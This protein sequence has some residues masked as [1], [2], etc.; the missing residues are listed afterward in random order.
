MGPKRNHVYLY[1]RETE[2][3]AEV[4]VITS[5]RLLAVKRKLEKQ[6]MNSLQLLEGAWMALPTP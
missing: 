6:G 5:H 4:T 1:K 3:K 2:E